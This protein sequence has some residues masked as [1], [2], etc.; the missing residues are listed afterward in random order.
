[1][2]QWSRIKAFYKS[3]EPLIAAESSNEWACSPYAWEDLDVSLTPIEAWLWH[4]IRSL[5][6][7]LYPQYPINGMFV[8]FANPKAKVVIECDGEAFHVDKEKDERRDAALRN[9]GWRVY[10]ITGRDCRDGVDDQ[11]SSG[12]SKAHLFLGQ[13]SSN[14]RIARGA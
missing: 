5:D 9:L 13:I 7:V 14:H 10:R 8:D 1:M 2:N 3:I 12:K 11:T 6:L 4:D